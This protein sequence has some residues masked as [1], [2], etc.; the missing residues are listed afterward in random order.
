MLPRLSQHAEVRRRTV[1]AVTACTLCFLRAS[2]IHHITSVY[3]ELA[4]RL[5]RC[6][7]HSGKTKG[8]RF[9]EAMGH[10]AEG[11]IDIKPPKNSV[12]KKPNNMQRI[13]GV[14][15]GQRF[16]RSAATNF[17]SSRTE[18]AFDESASGSGLAAL[19][20]KVEAMAQQ[21]VQILDALTRLE[22]RDPN[23]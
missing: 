20:R 4:M 3:P 10:A 7:A 16:A 13:G 17:R 19:T 9:T 14:A 8:K 21:Q 15:S 23:M 11:G 22:Q 1:T 6:G 5:R 18:G 12:F 2:R